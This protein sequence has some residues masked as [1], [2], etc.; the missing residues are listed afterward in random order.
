MRYQPDHKQEARARMIEAAGKGFRRSGYSGIGIDGLAKEAG[1][2]SG[3]FYGHFKSKQAAFCEA[4]LEGVDE[5]GDTVVALQDQLGDAW[6]ATFVDLYLEEKRTCALESS[7]ALQ[8][9]TADVQR[10]EPAIKA[11]FEDRAGR[12]IDAIA[13]GL[14]GEPVTRRDKAQA[15]IALLTGA[16]TL[17]RAMSSADAGSRIADAARA[18]ALAVCA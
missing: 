9:L 3:A 14:G 6:L 18:A 15:L 1:V 10:A 4:L 5:P 17:S 2:T 11:A 12:V 16:V 8:S 13:A 7:C